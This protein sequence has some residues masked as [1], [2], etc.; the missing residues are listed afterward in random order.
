MIKLVLFDIDNTLLDFQKCAD[1][2]MK[3][4]MKKWNLDLEPGY[5]EVF[6]EINNYYW[7]LLE[8]EKI[9]REELYKNRWKT[10]FEKLG[11]EDIDGVLFEK[12]F[13][14][15]LYKSHQK[16][17]GADEILEYLKDKYKLIIVSNS[18]YHEQDSRLTEAGIREY[19]DELYTSEEV[20]YPKPTKEFFDHVFKD[21]DVDKDE[22]IIIG[23]SI[24]ADIEGGKNYGIKTCWFNFLKEPDSDIPDFTIKNLTEL[25]EIL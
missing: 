8:K 14:N 4:A 22:V 11:I 15:F 21:I 3:E 24:K 17:D 13:V 25:K 16:I 2:A 10:V 6:M 23:D 5:F 1:F 12:D 19:F 18:S 7:D 20:G 9:T